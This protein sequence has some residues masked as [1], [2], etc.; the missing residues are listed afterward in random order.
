MKRLCSEIAG[1]DAAILVVNEAI[2][3]L[4]LEHVH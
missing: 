3:N 1:F 4:L 2:P